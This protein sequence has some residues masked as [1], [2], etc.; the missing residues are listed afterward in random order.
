MAPLVQGLI[1]KDGVEE[2]ERDWYAEVEMG[3]VLIE[4]LPLKSEVV[5]RPAYLLHGN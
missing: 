5:G 4:G 3:S 1:E 2:E